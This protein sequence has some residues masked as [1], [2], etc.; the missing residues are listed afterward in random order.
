M[1]RNFTA[2]YASTV[3]SKKIVVRLFFLFFYGFSLQSPVVAQ[4]TGKVLA[5]NALTINDGLS[6]GM[7]IRMFQDRYGFMWFATLDGLNRYDGFQFVI[8]RHDAQNETSITESYV[9]TIFEDTDGRLWVGTVSG[10]LDLFD[11]ETETF[12]HIRHK[13]GNASS[14]SPGPVSSIAEDKQGNIWVSVSDRLDKITINENKKT[15]NKTFSIHHTAAPF[16]S[17]AS[18]LF[19]TKT[20]TI[21]YADMEGAVLYKLEDGRREIWSVA[22][23]LNKYLLGQNK[24]ADAHNRIVQLLEDETLKK[25]YIFYEGGLLRLDEK[26]GVPEKVFLNPLFRNYTSPLQATLDKSG[27][28]WFSTTSKL[29]FFDTHSGQADYVKTEDAAIAQTLSHAYS[30]FIDRSGLLWVGTGGYGILKRNTRSETFHHTGSSSVYFITEAGDGKIIFGNSILLQVGTRRRT[31]KLFDEPVIENLK[32]K[33]GNLPPLFDDPFATDK[34]GA[35][36]ADSTQLR[37]LAKNRKAVDYPLPVH[38][39]HEYPDFVQ[40]A[41]KDSSG[42]I[43]LATTQGLLRFRIAD[44]NWQ[45]Y[46]NKISDSTSLSSNAVFSL[47]LDPAQ[48]QKYIW[49]GTSG[50]G[51]NRM[52]MHTGSCIR[53]TVK[54]GLPNNVI[55]GILPDEN[56]N[57]WMS[58]NKGLSC[59][60]PQKKS[61]RNFDY[62][63]GLQSNEFNRRAYYRTKDGCLFFGGVNGLNYFYPQ[64]IS[65]NKTVPQVVLTELKIQNQPV[66]VRPKG[67]PLTK[68]VYLTNK[69]TLTYEQNNISFEFAAMDFTDPEKNLYKYKLEGFETDWIHSGNIHNATYT[70]LDPG[71][72]T[73]MVKGSNNDGV[74]NEQETSIQVIILPP[75]YMTWWFRIA[76]AVALVFIAY[77]FYRYRLAQAL[78]LQAIRDRIAGDLHDEVGSNLSNIYIFS[79][80]AQQKTAANDAAAPLLQRITEYTQQSMEAMNDIV[81]MI[82][83][84][85]DLFENIM[86]RM[87]IIAAEFSETSG[88]LLHLDFD[89]KLNGVTLNME[90]RKNVYLIYKEAINNTAKYAACKRLWVQMQLNQNMVTLKIAD[91]GKGFDVANTHNGNGLYN[92]QKRAALLKGTLT[93]AS[94]IG[95]GTTLQL[96]FKV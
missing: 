40:C 17:E 62:K 8:Y 84:R 58:T 34:E 4:T 73:F 82:N 32:N 43:W 24:K 61:F 91:N 7:I 5:F 90:K 50:G 81:W 47:C 53:Y 11:R 68:V 13:E 80:I 22:F 67:A 60:A 65:N 9:Q 71:T 31:G 86:V 78:K 19:I 88:C 95:Q 18:F 76:V 27:V 29:V 85:N 89:E 10:G 69:V 28:I 44:A 92:M 14:L 12:I 66:P 72:Y 38:D 1:G 21:Y 74:W 49:I 39:N 55:Y 15:R 96:S 45:V 23:D 63:D 6:Q 77:S 2:K 94:T 59:F 64:E 3:P 52:D 30:T 48:P 57:L 56:G 36:F 87:R 26:T 79:N 51:L 54:D 42:T 16:R 83:T 25:L 46:K 33:T 37:Y 41:I 70:N 93:V 35:W 75:W 20:G